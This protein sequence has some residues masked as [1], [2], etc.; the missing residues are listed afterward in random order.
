MPSSKNLLLIGQKFGYLSIVARLDAKSKHNHF[1]WQ[2]SCDCGRRPVYNTSDL[3][4][5]LKLK[6]GPSCGCLYYHHDRTKALLSEMYSRL[7]CS[8][9]KR[10]AQEI[11]S[12][13]EHAS[14]IQAN[15]Y[16]CGQPPSNSH[17]TQ[18]K[19]G[20]RMTYGGIDRI[21]SSSG[22]I[23]GNVRPCCRRCNV[24]KSDMSS[25]D[26]IEH[27]RRIVRHT[28]DNAAFEETR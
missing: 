18:S 24:A 13:E 2:C 6:D 3:R 26:F 12:P 14:L 16:Y 17:K 8:H 1:L 7:R 23:T 25:D 9:R 5:K 22:Y 27:A 10:F 28:T 20:S 4:K 21:D 15:C 19:C 11:I